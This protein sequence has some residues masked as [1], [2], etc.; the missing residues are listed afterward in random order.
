MASL[1]SSQIQI[2]VPSPETEFLLET[3][4]KPADDGERQRSALQGPSGLHS[5]YAARQR[6]KSVRAG[7]WVGMIRLKKPNPKKSPFSGA[8]YASKS[9]YHLSLKKPT[10][11]LRQ[12]AGLGLKAS[13]GQNPSELHEALAWPCVM[14]QLA[15]PQHFIFCQI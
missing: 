3:L 10:L 9:Q 11:Q 2:H 6:L 12:Q 13:D 14:V 15:H 7:F 1:F 5:H 8:P 4:R